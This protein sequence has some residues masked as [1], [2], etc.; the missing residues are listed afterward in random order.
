MGREI[1]G[2]IA[3]PA[4]EDG[5]NRRKQGVHDANSGEFIA[6]RVPMKNPTTS[7][8]PRAASFSRVPCGRAAVRKGSR[9]APLLQP[10][11]RGA[12]ACSPGR[13]GG[14]RE[15]SAYRPPPLTNEDARAEKRM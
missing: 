6:H 9:R 4:V 7:D 12:S 1:G 11:R 8:Y 10:P 2:Q 5:E 3:Q 13:S 14:K 15:P